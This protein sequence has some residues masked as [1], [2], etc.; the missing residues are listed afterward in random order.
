MEELIGTVP[1][2]REWIRIGARL[3]A[4][5]A[6]GAVIGYQRAQPAQGSPGCARTCSSRWARH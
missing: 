5:L 2:A 6:V 4:A 1:D 3:L